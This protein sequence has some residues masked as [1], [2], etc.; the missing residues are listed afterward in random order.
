[1]RRSVGQVAEEVKAPGRIKQGLQERRQRLHRLAVRSGFE[2]EHSWDAAN[3]VSG[4][5]FYAID[6]AL[7]ILEDPAVLVSELNRFRSYGRAGKHTPVVYAV[8]IQSED[9]GQLSMDSTGMNYRGVLP[10]ERLLARVRISADRVVFRRGADH[11]GFIPYLEAMS[12][13]G[14]RIG[15]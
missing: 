5:S 2:S 7:N 6:Q 15:H 3:G 11:E 12:L 1:M 4:P 9:I 14:T 13:W 8:R 10:P